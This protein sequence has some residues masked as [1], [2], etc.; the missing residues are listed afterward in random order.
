MTEV[1]E[2]RER[3]EVGIPAKAFSIIEITEDRQDSDV[4]SGANGCH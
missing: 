4:G 2:A 3:G 1:R